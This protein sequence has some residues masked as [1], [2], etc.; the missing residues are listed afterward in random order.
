MIAT[1]NES[2]LHSSYGWR[3]G[4]YNVVKHVPDGRVVVK[5]TDAAASLIKKVDERG[6]VFLKL[7]DDYGSETK[8]S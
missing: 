4:D 2:G 3:K 7:E 6:N 1:V 5:Y 8:A